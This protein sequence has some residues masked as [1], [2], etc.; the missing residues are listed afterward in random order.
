[1]TAQMSVQI[2]TR[3][4]Q[5]TRRLLGEFFTARS[6]SELG[7]ET[8]LVPLTFEDGKYVGLL[9]VQVPASQ[10]D[11]AVWDLGASLVSESRVKAEASGR[12]SLQGGTAP[13]VLE[14]TV[15]F[16]PG[17]Y[18][19]VAVAREGREDAVS[20]TRQGSLWPDPKSAEVAAVSPI[21]TLQP[22]R[23]VFARQGQTRRGGSALRG[24]LQLQAGVETAFVS[25]VC[26]GATKRSLVI[27]RGL[28][29][30]NAH[31][32]APIYLRSEDQCIQV[33]DVIPGDYLGA[34]QFRYTIDVTEQDREPN[35]LAELVV[36]AN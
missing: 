28:G 16:D 10:W 11:G 27:D 32:F 5:L 25:V 21:S 15:S 18:E 20:S 6:V 14:R 3:T 19:L 34:G 1:V 36:S 30:E 23:A 31:S 35:R 8:G 13:V 12:I 22:A 26:R 2:P 4:E 9:Q 17:S 29:G 24:P 7:V 33:R